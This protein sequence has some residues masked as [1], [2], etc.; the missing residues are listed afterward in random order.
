MVIRSKFKEPIV[1]KMSKWVWHGLMWPMWEVRG[2]GSLSFL[3]S[4][5]FLSSALEC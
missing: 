1:Q 2:G 3:I 5:L 4:Y